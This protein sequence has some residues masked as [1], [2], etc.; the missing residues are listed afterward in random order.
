MSSVVTVKPGGI[1]LV[2]LI[3]HVHFLHGH[4]VADILVFL[5]VV[6]RQGNVNKVHF[7]RPVPLQKLEESD[8]CHTYGTEPIIEHLKQNNMWGGKDLKQGCLRGSKK[9]IFLNNQCSTGDS[10]TILC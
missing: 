9:T 8:F 1:Y 6:A 5:Y 7:P 3:N 10:K 4:L 2:F